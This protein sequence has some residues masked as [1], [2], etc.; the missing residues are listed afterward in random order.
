MT[1][2]AVKYRPKLLRD[3]LGNEDV[4]KSL[5]ALMEREDMPHTILFT[6]PS[7]CG[8]TTLARIVVARLKCSE[9]DFTEN[10]A[11][12]FRGIDSV[13]DI[14][15]QMT[16]APM[17][18][19]CRVWLLDEA[20]Q[21]SKDA[22][23]ALLKALED[24]PKRVYFLLA[25]TDPE[26]LLPTIKTRCVTF[27]VKPLGDKMMGQLLETVIKAEGDPEI[28][29][30][31]IDQIVQDSLGSARMALSILDKIINMDAGDMLEA[32][33]QQAANVNEAIDLCRALIGKK[34]WPVVAKI[35]KGIQQEP[36]SVRRA[37]LGY[38]QSV[39]LSSN[40]GQAYIVMSMFRAPFYDTGK[41]GLT[42]AC[43]EAIN[44]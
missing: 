5:K 41:P 18:G 4:T 24:T 15:K 6:G 34:P 21:L 2:L 10:N 42:I 28:P 40:N 8:K 16:F 33:K 22:Q 11:A 26:K 29:Q 31:V 3:F 23:H 36:E 1:S 19:P 27:D 17:A 13:R 38:A 32:A 7:G 25:T 9:F 20:H 44:G 39:L 14:I 37:V 35:V 12:D 43:F 30:E